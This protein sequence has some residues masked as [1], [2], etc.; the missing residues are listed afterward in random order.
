MLFATI[1][2]SVLLAVLLLASAGGK[3]T[4]NPQVVT[5][6]ASAGVAPGQFPLLAALEIA[7]AVGLV[8]GLLWAPLGI[9]AA[10]GVILYFVAAIVAHLRLGNWSIGPA[11]FYLILAVAALVLRIAI[12]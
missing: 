5:N 2:V 12:S 9:A 3:R 4:R 10:I 1:V 6:L 11:G 8:L 7:G